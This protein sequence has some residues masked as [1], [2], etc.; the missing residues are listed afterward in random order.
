ML[1]LDC[2]DLGPLGHSPRDIKLYSKI[3]VDTKPWLVDPKV[4]CIPWRSIELPAKLS[5]A[6]IKSN[7]VVNP[8]PPVARGMEIAISKLKEAGH[9]IIEWELSDQ[10][11]VAALS[12]CSY[13]HM[14]LRLRRNSILLAEQVRFLHYSRRLGNHSRKD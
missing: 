2:P 8:L 11:D 5:F 14:N 10:R 13:P 1:P 4:V 3:I 6:V 9:E 7:K 12:V